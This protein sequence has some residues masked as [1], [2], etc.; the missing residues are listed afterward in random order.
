MLVGG[1]HEPQANDGRTI[2]ILTVI[3]QFTRE[4]VWLEADRSM[5]GPKVVAALTRAIT[6]RGARPPSY[7]SGLRQR[8]CRTDDGSLG[9]ASW[10]AALLFPARKTGREWLHR[11]L[12][13][14]VAG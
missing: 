8:V 11:K 13:R 6:E 4:C 14:A 9:D 7:D 10:R 12:Q 5:N 1:F 3:D 2:R